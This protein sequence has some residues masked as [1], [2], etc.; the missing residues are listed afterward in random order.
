MAALNPVLIDVPMPIRTPRLLIRPK[1]V[2]DGAIVSAA[3]AETWDDLH[4]WM[5]W[6]EDRD[7]FTVE[8]MEIRNRRVMA[9]FLLREGI[10]L[11]GIETA[12][13]T[14]VVWCGLHD[15]DWEGRQCDTGF[16]VRK[17]AQGR[18]IATEAANAMVR[19]AF[20]ALGMRRVGLTHSAGN[21]ASRRIAEKL[22]FAFE[23]IQRGANVLAGG[24]CAD[25]YCYG[26]L[27]IAGLPELEVQW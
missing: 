8:L 15:I 11:M 24:R 22:G 7:A 9:G 26:R 3:V 1:Q 5:R 6:A 27:D 17:S 20:G 18:G 25:R 4:R 23:G 2:G 12:T 21:E 14:A 19:Y 13:G 10:E 16:W